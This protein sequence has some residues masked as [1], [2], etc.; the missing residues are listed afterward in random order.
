MIKGDSCKVHVAKVEHAPSATKGAFNISLTTIYKLLC[1][2]C[3]QMEKKKQDNK[4][5]RDQLNDEYLEVLDRQRIYFK[6]VKDF[7]EVRE[8]LFF[9]FACV[10]VKGFLLP[11]VTAPKL[12]VSGK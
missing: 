9:F 12:V 11:I 3:C 6:T 4:M 2:S 1:H 8:K 5:R 10:G 7:K